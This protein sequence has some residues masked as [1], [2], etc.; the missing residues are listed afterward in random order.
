MAKGKPKGAKKAGG[1]GPR[2][3]AARLTPQQYFQ[4]AQLALR[5]DDYDAARTAMRKAVQL[6]P[7]NVE[8]VDA[9]GALLAEIGPEEEAIEVGH[10]G[11]RVWGSGSGCQVQGAVGCC[12]LGA[13]AIQTL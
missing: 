7:R 11:V 8:Y 9:L 1:G 2:A 12:T 4:Q 10:R 5:Y 3:P 13:T 6:D